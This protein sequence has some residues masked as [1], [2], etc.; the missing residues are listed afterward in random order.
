MARPKLIEDGP[1]L[2]LIK[3]YFY[4]E[5]HN[6]IKKLKP[7]QIVKYINDN[8]YPEYP[9]TTLRRTQVA[10][11]YIEEL[12]KTLTDDNY[13]TVVSYQ[14]IDAALLVESNRSRDRLIK[15]ITERDCYY[16]TIADSAAQAFERYNHL[17]KQYES[18]K[19]NNALLAEK[20]SELEELILKYKLEIKTLTNELNVRKTVI[21]T[22]VYP[23]IANELLVKEGAIRKTEGFIKE[24]A[25]ESNLITTTTN[26]KNTSKSGSHIINGLFDILEE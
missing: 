10:M 5:C 16:K 4:E 14:A 8:G 20:N 15:A 26:V 7:S 2:D 21:E 6:D 12:K 19:E 24:D 3:K 22:Y 13:A 9:V 1:L 11:D 18:E 17:Q 23:E 25:F